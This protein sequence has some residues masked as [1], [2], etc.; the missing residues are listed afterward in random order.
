MQQQMTIQ[1]GKGSMLI[2][3]QW[4]QNS[5]QLPCIQYYRNYEVELI[6]R[7]NDVYRVGGSS[8]HWG[9]G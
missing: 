4:A 8:A 7:T 1:G 3:V 2:F 6:N 5:E 9:Q